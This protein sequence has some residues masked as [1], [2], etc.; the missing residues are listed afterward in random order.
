MSLLK[1]TY[2]IQRANNSH[3]WE[4]WVQGTKRKPFV[5][6]F[7][8]A[9]I[10]QYELSNDWTIDQM[11]NFNFS[12]HFCPF[13]WICTFCTRGVF[14]IGSNIHDGALTLFALKLHHRV[15]TGF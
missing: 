6:K 9:E 10:K 14:R 15:F 4:V 13:T 7:L 11:T 3:S 5:Q 1:K 2:L 8:K 12:N